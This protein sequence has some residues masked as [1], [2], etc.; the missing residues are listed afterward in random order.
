MP[1]KALSSESAL[2]ELFSIVRIHRWESKPPS[3]RF[4]R[5]FHYFRPLLCIHLVNKGL[6]PW[7]PAANQLT[8][9]KSCYC[10]FIELGRLI[11]EKCKS[12]YPPSDVDDYSYHIWGLNCERNYHFSL[13]FSTFQWIFTFLLHFPYLHQ[14]SRNIHF[15]NTQ[16]YFSSF[17][18][19]HV[20]EKLLWN[21]CVLKT[22]LST[23]CGWLNDL[24]K[25]WEK[26]FT[27]TGSIQPINHHGPSYLL[28][29]PLSF[30]ISVQLMHPHLFCLRR[31][32]QSAWLCSETFLYKF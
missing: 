12:F 17:F 8:T 9:R 10:S 11:A 31:I 13:F 24:K 23:L 21:P 5:Y 27:C 6:L 28:F 4:F 14:G 26:E 29:V 2:Q 25:W 32:Q 1:T 18:F 30:F 16:N 7:D 19:L 22:V 20:L 15:N 3:N